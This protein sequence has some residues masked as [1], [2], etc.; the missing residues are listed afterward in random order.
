MK[1]INLFFLILLFTTKLVAQSGIPC[2]SDEYHFRVVQ[3]KQ[4]LLSAFED[5]RQELNNF[6]ANFQVLPKSGPYIIPMVFHVIH[7]NGEENISD[8]QI[9]DAVKQINEQFNKR[10]ADTSQTV[11]EFKNIAANVGIEFRLAK[12]GPNGE[13]TNGITRNFSSSSLTGDHS[14]KDV[15]HWPREKYINVYV[16]K[17]AAG[18]AGHALMPPVADTLPEWDGIVM[19]HSYV[20][21]IGTSR[22]AHRTVL[23]HELGHFFNLYH[24]WGGNNVPNFYYLPV[25]QA[26]NCAYDDD[27]QDTPNTIGW[28][29]CSLTGSSCGGINNVQNFMDYSYCSTMFTEGQKARM[30]AALNSPI[31]QRNN[32]WS[33]QNLSATGIDQTGDLCTAAFEILKPY[34]C[35]NDT[36]TIYDRSF[37]NIQSRVWDIPTATIIEQHDSIVRV[38]FNSEGKHT[39][40]LTVS[41]GLTSQTITKT[42]AIEILPSTISN[43]Y[44]VEDFEDLSANYRTVLLNDKNN[45]Q[46]TNLAASGNNAYYSNNFDNAENSYQFDLRPVNLLNVTNPSIQFDRAFARIENSELETLEIKV[47]NNCGTDWNT[48][49]SFTSSNLKTITQDITTG[50]FVPTSSEWQTMNS[51]LIPSGYRKAHTMIRFSYIGKGFNDLY[52]DNINIGAQAQ[53][54]TKQLTEDELVIY[55]NPTS[56][57]ITLILPSEDDAT[58]IL[59][60]LHGKKI[61]SYQT[62]QQATLELNLENYPNGVYFVELKNQTKQITQKIILN[63]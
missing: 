58:V 56:G 52:L 1:K 5:K 50:P 57:T 13:C 4:H 31:A 32:L 11:T 51:F 45:W 26:G 17:G 25:A 44:L 39:I 2:H 15:I 36:I 9:H 6:T 19:Q 41:D 55:P 38:K 23:T 63:K 22:W 33:A 40:S 54:S 29:S 37:H 27:V 60:D 42:E 24:I 16:C 59:S 28:Q 53:L 7:A 43:A 14:V 61:A 8:E 48:I 49:R 46:F 62:Q 47:S 21:T 30:I 35:L 3:E 10:N 20:G 12:I 18:L 34:G